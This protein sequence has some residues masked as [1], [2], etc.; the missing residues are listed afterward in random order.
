MVK[1]QKNPTPKKTSI[2]SKEKKKNHHFQRK[3][4]KIFILKK[5]KS[6]LEPKKIRIKIKKFLIIRNRILNNF[7]KKSTH[8]KKRQITNSRISNKNKF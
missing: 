4:K 7:K 8:K 3:S 5:N 6:F 1:A 2:S